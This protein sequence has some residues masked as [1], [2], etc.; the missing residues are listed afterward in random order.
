M[1]FVYH[2]VNFNDIYLD[3][4]NLCK[5]YNMHSNSASLLEHFHLIQMLCVKFCYL[6]IFYFLDNVGVYLGQLTLGLILSHDPA[7][8]DD[9]LTRLH[10]VTPSGR[11]ACA[12]SK[13]G[14]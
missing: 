5:C 8:L 1:V 4:R 2:L 14:I 9:L 6:F 3:H 10:K 11:Y 13:V 12:Y 7:E